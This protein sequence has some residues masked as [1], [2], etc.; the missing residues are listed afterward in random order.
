MVGS[1]GSRSM[2]TIDIVRYYGPVE[3]NGRDGIRYILRNEVYV[4]GLVL[5]KNSEQRSSLVQPDARHLRRSMRMCSAVFLR[6]SVLK[7]IFLN[8]MSS[9]HH[10]AK[11]FLPH[12]AA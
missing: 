1:A 12:S 7:L 4:C 3:N 11:S 5:A 6:P 8:S 2:D 10:G 9:R